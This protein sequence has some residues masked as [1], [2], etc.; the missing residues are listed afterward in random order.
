MN[1]NYLDRIMGM[2]KYYNLLFILLIVM[3]NISFGFL[4]PR[5]DNWGHLG[6]LI[7]GFFLI[8][9]IHKPEEAGDGM[10]C[11]Y[12]IWFIISAATLSVLYIGGLLIFYLVRKTK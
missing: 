11:R 10:C 8:F 2:N 1:W 7:F 5:I 4:N 3:L 9:V 6:G 12:Q